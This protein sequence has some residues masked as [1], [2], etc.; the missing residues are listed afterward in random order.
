M[1]NG[2]VS[3]EEDD[4]VRLLRYAHRTAPTVWANE[5]FDLCSCGERFKS[6]TS[7]AHMHAVLS[8]ARQGV[9]RW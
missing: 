5:R 3:I 7:S 2:R 4:F 8:A 1:K 9:Y 6:G